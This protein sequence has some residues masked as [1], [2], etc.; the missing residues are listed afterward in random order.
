MGT[1]LV[2]RDKTMTWKDLV[3]VTW[4]LHRDVKPDISIMYR[5][6]LEYWC[7]TETAK[8]LLVIECIEKTMF[9]EK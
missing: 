5:N 2:K 7:N 3:D 9:N 1:N 8:R 6:T 4:K